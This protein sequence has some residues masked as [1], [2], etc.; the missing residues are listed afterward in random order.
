LLS[1]KWE[2]TNRKLEGKA[3]GFPASVEEWTG[4]TLHEAL[5]RRI[6]EIHMVV[7]TILNAQDNRPNVLFISIDDLRP[8]LGC[9]ESRHNKRNPRA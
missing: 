1:S 2:P 6:K 3:L 5:G 8:E 9:Y 7:V 4:F